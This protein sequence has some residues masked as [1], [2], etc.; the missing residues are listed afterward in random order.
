MKQRLGW[1]VLSEA[2]YQGQTQNLDQNLLGRAEKLTPVRPIRDTKSRLA[3]VE[4][5][6]D[7]GARSLGSNGDGMR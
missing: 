4:S 7:C 2:M 1:T 3:E 5:D 6:T